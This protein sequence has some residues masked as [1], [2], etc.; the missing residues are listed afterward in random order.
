MDI[1]WGIIIVV[2]GLFLGISGLMKS[3]FVVYRILASRSKLLWKDN[4]HTFYVVVGV[5]LII[6]G[7]LVATGVI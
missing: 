6:F 2:I 1:I 5:M 4:V 3:D 7:I